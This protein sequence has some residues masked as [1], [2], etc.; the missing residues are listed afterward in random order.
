MNDDLRD[1]VR[2]W[3]AKADEDWWVVQVMTAQPSYPASLVCYHCQ[4]YVEKLRT[5]PGQSL[6]PAQS[7]LKALLTAHGIES[8]RSHDLRRLIEMTSPYVSELAILSD[9]ADI[10]TSYA[11]QSRYP[12]NWRVI[13]ISEAEAMV[14]LSR[15]FAAF[16]IPQLEL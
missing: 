4:Q 15:E 11:A 12:D 8:P 10:L 3:I 9:R 16:L 14:V 2:Q 1:T 5:C 13:E 7:V 6:C